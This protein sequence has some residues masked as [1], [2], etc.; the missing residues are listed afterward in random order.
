MRIRI[1]QVDAF[2][3][4]LF[5]GNPA[6]VCPLEEWLP[7]EVLQD[8]AAENDLSETGFVVAD[9]D[10]YELRWFTPTSEVD[11]CGH[12]T[13]AA[14]FVVLRYMEG[15][16]DRVTFRTR[17]GPLEV[18]SEDEL[19]SMRF[20]GLPPEPDPEGEAAGEALGLRPAGALRA[21]DHL[22]VYEEAE[23]VASLRPDM[24]RV[25]ALSGRGVIATAPAGDGHE[26]DFVSR[27]FAPG[28]GVP[29]DPVTGSA[30]CTL[31]PYWADRLGRDRL[32][33]R[34]ISPRGG[35]VICEVEGD[36]VVLSGGAVLYLEGTIRVPGVGPREEG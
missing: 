30:H 34:Q 18:W 15:S 8:V 17:S 26:A 35:T 13:L 21:K 9:G 28:V 36:R 2:T 22:A 32:V 3:D 23:E 31:A 27:F 25:E 24:A 29:E 14:G 1:F 16:R 11:L 33:G 12:A 4:R 7:D 5:G 10:G 6:A 20:P 19:L